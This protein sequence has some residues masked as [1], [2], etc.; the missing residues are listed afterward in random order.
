MNIDI[1]DLCTHCGRNTAWGSD[2]F[3]NRIPSDSDAEVHLQ[4]IDHEV[5][6][7]MDDSAS[8]VNVTVTGYMCVE[9]QSLPCDRCNQP[10]AEY[11]TI[12]DG[13]MKVCGD[14]LEESEEN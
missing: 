12:D 4:G 3:I 11:I 8:V 9:C 14:C 5:W 2:L 1:R 7:E 13:T 6:P 10:T